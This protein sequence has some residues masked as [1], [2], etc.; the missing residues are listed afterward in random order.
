M[1]DATSEKLL[2]QIAAEVKFAALPEVLARLIT[3]FDDPDASSTEVAS[4]LSKD[5]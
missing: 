5:A 2:E 1:D 3:L 4:L